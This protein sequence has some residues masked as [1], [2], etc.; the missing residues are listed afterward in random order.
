M[1]QPTAETE[2]AMSKWGKCLISDTVISLR[3]GR[4]S[5]VLFYDF[6]NGLEQIKLLLKK[7]FT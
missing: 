6:F 3:H 2:I 1:L 4:K 5:L 7:Y